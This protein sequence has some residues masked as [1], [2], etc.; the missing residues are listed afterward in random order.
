[1]QIAASVLCS[2]SAM[3]SMAGTAF[4][5]RSGSRERRAEIA[6][7]LSQRRATGRFSPRE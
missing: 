6:D 7:F 3:G 4:A 5:G 2:I 1:V